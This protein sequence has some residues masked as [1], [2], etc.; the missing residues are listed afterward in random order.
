MSLKFG[1]LPLFLLGFCSVT[2][3]LGQQITSFTPTAGSY[4]DPNYVNINGTG[5]SPGTLVV[6]FGTTQDFT[7]QATSATLI[8]ARVPTNAPLGPCHISVKVGSNPEVF[9][10][11]FFVV[12]GPGP[13]ISDFSPTN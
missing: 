3:L 5:F 11:D 10:T 6:K 7:A 8:L 12:I 2:R 9:S 4:S 1:F 13:Y